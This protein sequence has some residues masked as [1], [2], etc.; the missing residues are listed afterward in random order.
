MNEPRAERERALHALLAD[1][2]LVADW[3]CASRHADDGTPIEVLYVVPSRAHAEHAWR[4]AAESLLAAPPG[5]GRVLLVSALPLAADGTIDVDALARVPL[6]DAAFAERA[7]ELAS[8]SF[9]VECAAFVVGSSLADTP[10][11]ASLLLPKPPAPRAGQAHKREAFTASARGDGP[12]SLLDG[13]ELPRDA[14]APGTL[15]ACLESAAARASGA[16][17]AIGADDREQRLEYAELLTRARAGAAELQAAGLVAGTPVLLQFE[18]LRDFFEGFWACIAA[19]LIPVPSA[20]LQLEQRGAAERLT[21]IWESLERPCVLTQ[22]SLRAAL[23]TALATPDAAPRVMV[24]TRDSALPAA[25]PC[26]A[27]PDDTAL[28]MLTSGSTGTPKAVRLSHR[29]LLSRGRGSQLLHGFTSELRSLN[30]MPLDHV[31]GLIYFHLRDVLLGATQVHVPTATVLRDP[32]RWLDLCE[33]Y[34]ADITFAPNFAFGLINA[35]GTDIVRRRWDLSRLRRVLNGAE[36]IVAR[37]AREFMQLLTPHGLSRTA[38]IPAWGMAEVSSGITYNLEFDLDRVRDE[39]RHVAVGRPIPGT[40]ARIV[41]EHDKVVAEG[42]E[43]RLQIQGATTFAGYWQPTDEPVFTDDGWFRTGDL[44]YVE[45]GRLFITGREKDTINIG[46]IKYPGPAIEAAVDTVPGV[47]SS[48]SA[49]LAVQDGGDGAERLAVAFVPEYDRDATLRVLLPAIRRRIGAQLGVAADLLLPLTR[50]QVPKTSIGKIQRRQMQNAFAAGEYDEARRRF[51]ILTGSGES[52]PRWFHRREWHAK[53]ARGEARL[54]DGA[55]ACLHWA[56]DDIARLREALAGRREVLAVDG[57]RL[58]ALCAAQR[59]ALVCMALDDEH[60]APAAVI[61]L[62][63]ALA[64]GNA[65]CRVLITTRGGLAVDAVEAARPRLAAAAVLARAIAQ[66]LPGISVTHIDSDAPLPAVLDALMHGDDVEIAWRD[67]RRLVPLLADASL[68]PLSDAPLRR[69][70]RYLLSGGLGGIGRLLAERLVQDYAA[71]VA[72]LGRRPAAELD[73]VAQAWLAKPRAQGSIVY[74]ATD[75]RDG[76]AVESALAGLGP[77]WCAPLDG[78]FHLA[79]DY[80]EARVE[81]E[82]AA[83]VADA[84]AIKLD[85]ARVLEARV[86]RRADAV[87]VSF[88]SLLSELV[89]AEVGAYAAASRALEHAF[90]GLQAGDGPRRYC[91]A[92]GSWRGIGMSRGQDSAVAL[93]ARGIV[94]LDARQAGNALLA[95][96]GQAPG[97]WL[98]GLNPEV[99]SIARRAPR[100]LPLERV[101]VAACRPDGTPADLTLTDDSGVTVAVEVVPMVEFPRD[102]DGALDGAALLRVLEADQHAH[103]EP[104]DSTEARLKTLWQALLGIERVSVED[105]FF[106]VGG[107]SLLA[108]Q[109]LGAVEAEFGCRWT[110]RDVFAAV[111]IAAQAELLRQ[112]VGDGVADDIPPRPADLVALPLSSA[113]RRIWFSDQLER[114]DPLWNIHAR[115]TWQR[116][117]DSAAL[118]RALWRLCERHETLRTRFALVD[119]EPRQLVAPAPATFLTVTDLGAVPAAQRA[120]AAARI[121]DSEARWRFDLSEGPLLRAQLL[122]FSDRHYELLLTT[123]HVIGD[124]WSMRIL[125]DELRALYDAELAGTPVELPALA[126]QY[127]DYALWQQRHYAPE[128][129]AEHL[130]YWRAQLD[131]VSTGTV[132]RSDHPRPAVRGSRGQQLRVPL[133]AAL[134]VASE[135]SRQRLGVSQTVW[136]LACFVVLLRRWSGDRDVTL[137]TVVA[138]RDAPATH[139]LIGMFANLAIVRHLCDDAANFAQLCAALKDTVLRLHEHSVVPYEMVV[140]QCGSYRDPQFAPLFQI[141]FDVRDERLRDSGSPELELAV[142]ER[143][144]GRVQYDLHLTMEPGADGM[145]ALWSYNTDLYELATVQRLADAFL[146]LATAAAA[147]PTTACAQLPLMTAAARQQVMTDFNATALSLN[148]DC[149]HRQ[150]AA[151]AQRQGAALALEFESTRVDYAQLERDSGSVAAALQ[152]VGVVRGDRVALAVP[153]SAEMIIAMLGILRAGAAFVPIDVSYPADRI[154][155]ILGDADCRAVLRADIDLPVSARLPEVRVANAIALGATPTPCAVEG[156]DLAYL[157]YT[158]GSTGRPK[159]VLI[160]H[161]GL[162]NMAGG[163]IH[164]LGI[165]ADDRVLQFSSIGFDAVVFETFNALLAGAALILGTREALL[166]GPP[167]L[168]FIRTRRVSMAVLVPS[169]LQVLPADA[170]PDL[171]ILVS[172]GEA[173]SLELARQWAHRCALWNAYGPT[174][175]SVCTTLGRVPADVQAAPDIGAP[176][177]NYR[178]Y[179]LDEHLAPVPIG[180]DGELCIAGPSVARG[181]HGRADLTAERFLPDPFDAGGHGRLFRSG[182]FA[183]WRADGRLAFVG[184]RDDQLKLRGVRIEIGEIEA[185][186]ARLPGVAA[187]VVALDPRVA[188]SE[189][190]AFVVADGSVPVHSEG[191]RAGL[192]ALLPVAM[193]PARYH[194]VAAIPV[195]SS[196]KADRRALER[197][198]PPLVRA[199]ANQAPLDGASLEARIAAVWCEVL[200]CEEVDYHANFFDIGGHSLKVAKVNAE[201]QARLGRDIPLIE[202]FR[203]TTVASLAEHLR[204]SGAPE[205][206]PSA[207]RSDDALTERVERLSQG[208]ASLAALRARRAPDGGNHRT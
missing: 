154:D 144:I 150:I 160:D 205:S 59:P 112:A 54:R 166:P 84:I 98:I 141:A 20:T 110:M 208:R 123:H 176:I 80:H 136:M 184:R 111:T 9:A 78:A 29:N 135:T 21:A 163:V 146:Q 101:V 188:G 177:P 22:D 85:G 86:A 19:G 11:H 73:E 51:E 18:D 199:A 105:S 181:Y 93:G 104:R 97:T 151:L 142:M 116:D 44:A 162:A 106:D 10:Y 124:G 197:G 196:G 200:A 182:D 133:P 72:L 139:G 94:A 49:A 109:L 140:E 134:L 118:G 175:A 13:G 157:I 155:Y 16:L 130:A 77:A 75:V 170:L 39:D 32:L 180:V 3:H 62:A 15:L 103:V 30:W 14:N 81:A 198:L 79:A 194:F 174:E 56:D 191:L 158:S 17:I 74:A 169:V 117:V 68:R 82:S 114:G 152:S 6:V 34:Q 172:A 52:L 36:A 189:L 129:F 88:S 71:D 90:D 41:D 55:V 8:R 107:S 195:T 122:K 25:P 89:G 128:Y 183:R 192:A 67:G 1:E 178:V 26:A 45:A 100:A 131:G 76:A 95:V 143:D 57:A 164:T 37:T 24:L 91:L 168:D 28:M 138:H 23:G 126:I 70:G 4:S 61:E 7:A 148:S 33:R 173:L 5:R 119:G 42:V 149:A 31:A 87:F 204:G 65:A 156:D 40:R 171:R 179:V 120:A 193:I 60:A 165:R 161:R 102:A 190:V 187:A 186:L 27:A 201:L 48:F 53:A 115:V 125:F 113:Q 127:A 203:F 38:M 159:G 64:S 132:L 47:A 92:W 167:L 69:G 66:E 202:H 121:A 147:S 35:R 58:G 153:R 207:S 108:T 50:A 2:P 43:G 96:L 99:M 137:G 63:A 46:G 185:A 83:A 206:S 145:V 12:P